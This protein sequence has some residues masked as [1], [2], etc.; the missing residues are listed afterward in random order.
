M[1][2]GDHQ[3]FCRVVFL[4]IDA[5]HDYSEK[6]VTPVINL[7]NVPLMLI[8]NTSLVPMKSLPELI[9]HAKTNLGWFTF[10]TLGP[11]SPHEIGF[12]WLKSLS[13][14][15]RSFRSAN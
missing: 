3:T 5:G 13:K 14:M 2:E 7:A 12:Q 9:A 4:S 11:G 15:E 10:G 6:D 1:A 8:V